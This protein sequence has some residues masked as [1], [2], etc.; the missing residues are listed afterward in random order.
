M[1]YL[2]GLIGW[3][4][5]NTMHRYDNFHCSLSGFTLFG[6]K[7]GICCLGTMMCIDIR[8]SADLQNCF[9]T[10]TFAVCFV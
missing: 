7:N 1:S 8:G 3:W 2:L 10:L 6:S 4:I 5:N 9:V